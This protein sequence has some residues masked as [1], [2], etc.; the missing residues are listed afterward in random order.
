MMLQEHSECISKHI[1]L[2]RDKSTAAKYIG[3]EVPSHS[4]LTLMYKGQVYVQSYMSTHTKETTMY[5][6][7]DDIRYNYDFKLYSGDAQN[8]L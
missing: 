3:R 5:S 6:I 8:A 2:M 7:H 1:A 4:V